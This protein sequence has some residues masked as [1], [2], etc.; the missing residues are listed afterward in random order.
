MPYVDK[1]GR[2][3]KYG[4]FFPV[5]FSPWAYNET[6]AQEYFPLTKDEAIQKGYR[7]RDPD[8]KNY[9]PTISSENIPSDITKTDETITKEILE[10]AHKMSCNQGCTKAFRI[11][12]N[13]LSF[14][15]KIGVPLPILCPACRTMERL[16][17]RL[18][19]KLHDRDCMCAGK[20]DET[21]QYKNEAVHQHAES[22]CGEK[23]KTGYPI[24]KGDIVYCEK[25][26]QQEVY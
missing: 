24:E 18:G 19:V 22:H 9:A 12:S 13:E 21:G 3:Y 5:E 26:Y 7:W 25:C 11:L 6:I 4:E 20:T 14:Y 1:K 10:C 17:L 23:F 8:T 2:V 16:K 15:K